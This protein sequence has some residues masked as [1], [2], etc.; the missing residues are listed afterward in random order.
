MVYVARE[1]IP[2]LPFK[3]NKRHPAIEIVKQYGDISEV[4]CYPGQLNGVFMNILANAIDAFEEA[5]AGKSYDE[6]RT[7][8][9]LEI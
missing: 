2:W 4:I 5:N 7:Y 6:I 1:F 9:Y 3:A 8:A